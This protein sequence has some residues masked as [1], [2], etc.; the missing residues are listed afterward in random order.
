MDA[1]D[2]DCRGTDNM[3]VTWKI[4]KGKALLMLCHPQSKTLAALLL[5]RVLFR[6]AAVTSCTA[7]SGEIEGFSNVKIASV[8]H[9]DD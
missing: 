5:V 7:F 2:V 4:I 6:L 8:V 1:E 3:T 9:F